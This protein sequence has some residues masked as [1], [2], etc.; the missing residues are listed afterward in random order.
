MKEVLSLFLLLFVSNVV[1]RKSDHKWTL[2]RGMVYLVRYNITS[3][4]ILLW[5]LMLSSY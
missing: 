3:S 2:V 4:V 5:L 1:D